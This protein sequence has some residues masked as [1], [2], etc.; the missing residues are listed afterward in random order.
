MKKS[1]LPSGGGGL[2]PYIEIILLLSFPQHKHLQKSGF[3]VLHILYL[4]FFLCSLE[5]QNQNICVI[6]AYCLKINI[7]VPAVIAFVEHSTK[8]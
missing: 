1:T 3:F 4:S 2:Q 5:S 8:C 7:V 6:R